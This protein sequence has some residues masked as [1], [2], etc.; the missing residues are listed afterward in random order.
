MNLNK[1]LNK[2]TEFIPNKM[3]NVIKLFFIKYSLRI[4]KRLDQTVVNIRLLDYHMSQ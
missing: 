1:M 2:L 3:L 4:K